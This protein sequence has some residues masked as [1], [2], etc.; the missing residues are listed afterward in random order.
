M[1]VMR[2]P[3]VYPEV[4]AERARRATGRRERRAELERVERK[5][6]ELDVAIHIERQIRAARLETKLRAAGFR[7]VNLQPL[8]LEQPRAYRELRDPSAPAQEGR[9]RGALVHQLGY[10]IGVR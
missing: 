9:R 3:Y 10:V 7:N 2:R 5:L 1:N 4:I 8:P 6:R